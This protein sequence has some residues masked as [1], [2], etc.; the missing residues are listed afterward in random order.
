MTRHEP[1]HRNREPQPRRAE[2]L[3]SRHVAKN[4]C[5]AIVA[6]NAAA[7]VLN[8]TV[9]AIGGGDRAHWDNGLDR[10]GDAIGSMNE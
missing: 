1:P 5:R 4:A 3:K 7:E 10:D 9:K 8:A 2:T 6:R